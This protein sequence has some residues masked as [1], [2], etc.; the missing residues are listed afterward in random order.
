[1]AIADPDLVNFSDGQPCEFGASGLDAL[2]TRLE[3][4]FERFTAKLVVIVIEI[5]LHGDVAHDYGWHDLTLTPRD[6]GQPTRRRDRYVDIW[7]KNKEG[8]WKLWMYM[9]NQDVADPFRPE[10]TLGRGA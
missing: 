2:K 7:R 10:Q 8:K 3:N 4:M 9:D 1:L 5:R 6:G